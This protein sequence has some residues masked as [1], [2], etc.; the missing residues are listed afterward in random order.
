MGYLTHK[1]EIDTKARFNILSPTMK[2]K[3]KLARLKFVAIALALSVGLSAYA[4][5]AREELV[6]AH[7]LLKEANSHYGGHKEKAMEEIEAAGHDMGL[8]MG[9]RLAEHERGWKSDDQL[10]EARRLLRD[11]REKLEERDRKHAAARIDHAIKEI[12]VAL[13]K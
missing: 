7:H 4:E 5:S 13:H 8:D 3:S 6:H 1:R 10:V 2:L 9:G 11:A 12:D